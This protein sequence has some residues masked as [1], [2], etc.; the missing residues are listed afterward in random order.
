MPPWA[1]RSKYRPSNS[2]SRHQTPAPCLSPHACT[3]TL[4]QTRTSHAPRHLWAVLLVA[5]ETLAAGPADASFYQVLEL[6]P[7][8]SQKDVRHNMQQ[9]TCRMRH[10]SSARLTR[11]T[12]PM[13]RSEATAARIHAVHAVAIGHNVASSCGRFGRERSLRFSRLMRSPS[14]CVSGPRTRCFEHQSTEGGTRRARGELRGC[15][16]IVTGGPGTERSTPV[17]KGMHRRSVISSVHRNSQET[18]SSIAG[19]GKTTLHRQTVCHR[20]GILFV[21]FAI[22]AEPS[23]A[24]PCSVTDAPKAL[25]A[26]QMASSGS[27]MEAL[28]VSLDGGM[29]GSCATCLLRRISTPESVVFDCLLGVPFCRT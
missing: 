11:V 10:A 5:A 3:S 8:C 16:P 2:P 15:S 14:C 18:W 20:T 19:M 26:F 12:R 9:S 25:S 21:A 29:E 1:Q 23:L 28:I 7:D 13:R 27:V 4:R 6:P 17:K 24:A 22:H